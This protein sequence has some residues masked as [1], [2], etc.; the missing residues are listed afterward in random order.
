MEPED[1]V[2]IIVIEATEDETVAD[3]LG[4]GRVM[5]GHGTRLRQRT[6]TTLA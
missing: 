3:V 2:G 6:D 4:R 1:E 5:E